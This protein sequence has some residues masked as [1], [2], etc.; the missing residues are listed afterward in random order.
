M[1]MPH[2]KMGDA[3]SPF[4]KE[5]MLRNEL[6]RYKRR[7]VNGRRIDGNPVDYAGL[8]LSG[9][10]NFLMELGELNHA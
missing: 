7:V 9:F 10:G 6:V 3:V 4:Q 2:S 1:M 5:V 8:D